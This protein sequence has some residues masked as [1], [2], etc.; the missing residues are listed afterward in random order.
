MS[1]VL[2]SNLS[3]VSDGDRLSGG[4]LRAGRTYQAEAQT[5]KEGQHNRNQ[6]LSGLRSRFLSSKVN[7]ALVVRI[8]LTPDYLHER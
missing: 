1:H 8:V 2:E 7:T 4:H 5:L 6:I 3:G